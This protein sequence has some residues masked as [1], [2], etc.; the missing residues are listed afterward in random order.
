MTGASEAIGQIFLY[1]AYKNEKAS[2]VLLV[3]Y[4]EIIFG[5][6]FDLVIFK[7][8]LRW[9]DYLASCLIFMGTFIIFLHKCRK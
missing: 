4:C 1:L 2:T 5:I 3:S 7:S 8:T 9:T 6:V